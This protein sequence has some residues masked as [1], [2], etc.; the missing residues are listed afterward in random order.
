M[1]SNTITLKLNF[2]SFGITARHFLAMR[3]ALELAP[4]SYNETPYGLTE[5]EH[6]D[7][8]RLLIVLAM[9]MSGAEFQKVLQGTDT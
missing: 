1:A 9:H 5:A 8:D 3:K 6:D 2:E 4:Q 7:A